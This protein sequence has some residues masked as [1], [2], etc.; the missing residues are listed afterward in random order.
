MIIVISNLQTIEGNSSVQMAWLDTNY[1]ILKDKINELIPLLNSAVELESLGAYNLKVSG[2]S[3]IFEGPFG[4]TLKKALVGKGLVFTTGGTNPTTLF[5]I[6]SIDGLKMKASLLSRPNNGTRGMKNLTIDSNGKIIQGDIGNFLSL[7]SSTAGD[8]GVTDGTRTAIFISGSFGNSRSSGSLFTFLK[9]S[10]VMQNNTNLL[11]TVKCVYDGERLLR[12]QLQIVLGV[13]SVLTDSLFSTGLIDRNPSSYVQPNNVTAALKYLNFAIDKKP[14]ISNNGN[15]I[16]VIAV[17]NDRPNSDTHQPVTVGGTAIE[18]KPTGLITSP[19]TRFKLV[20]SSNG[21]N[22]GA[23]RVV[24]GITHLSVNLSNRLGATN[25]LKVLGLFDYYGSETIGTVDFVMEVILFAQKVLIKIL[26]TEGVYQYK[27]FTVPALYIDPNY[28]NTSITL[29]NGFGLLPNSTLSGNH[30]LSSQNPYTPQESTGIPQNNILGWTRVITT[31]SKGSTFTRAI[32]PFTPRP[33][34]T[35]EF[36]TTTNDPATHATRSTPV[37]SVTSSY[38]SVLNPLGSG[39]TPC[40]NYIHTPNLYFQTMLGYRDTEGDR[41]PL[42]N[43]NTLPRLGVL[44]NGRQGTG[45]RA[46]IPFLDRNAN[47]VAGGFTV[48][49]WRRGIY[50]IFHNF[51]DYKG[52]TS[53]TQADNNGAFAL[54][55]QFVI[56]DAKTDTNT[57]TDTN[58]HA[59]F[60]TKF[61]PDQARRYTVTSARAI[62]PTILCYGYN[63]ILFRLT[64]NLGMPQDS[65]SDTNGTKTFFVTCTLMQIYRV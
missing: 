48:I 61:T 51:A 63:S 23:L 31:A 10:D 54:L 38:R 35:I 18:S 17:D 44:G 47:R 4:L 33:Y 9:K 59:G 64:N 56:Q 39:H 3:L 15:Y 1:N 22:G 43:I 8:T 57:N 37:S 55:P 5:E 62:T 7:V 2:T 50:E 34:M 25:A 49:K 6:N 16:S 32:L 45:T 14:F 46:D 24:P 60:G 20:I 26:T 30:V 53:S 41:A 11:A 29:T 28:I 40:I 42:P 21:A 65:A 58:T 13:N 52:Y 12:R 36:K 27:E 19:R